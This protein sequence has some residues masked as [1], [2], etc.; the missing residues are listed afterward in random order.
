MEKKNEG[1]EEL[2]RKLEFK[3]KSVIR[4]FETGVII[5]III[6]ASRTN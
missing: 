6:V 4:A 5:I 3:R 2:L 1:V